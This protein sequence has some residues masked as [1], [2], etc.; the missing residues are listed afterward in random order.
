MSRHLLGTTHEVDDRHD[1]QDKDECSETDIHR[2]LLSWIATV[3]DDPLH[4]S[5]PAR[6]RGS[7]RSFSTFSWTARLPNRSAVALRIGRQRT[8]SDGARSWPCQSRLRP[9]P[10]PCRPSPSPRR[11]GAQPYPLT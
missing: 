9:S 7:G 2:N 11:P 3:G 6:I 10:R 1:H 4:V 5:G 8:T